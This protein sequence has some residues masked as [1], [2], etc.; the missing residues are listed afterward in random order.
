MVGALVVHTLLMLAAYRVVRKVAY[1]K[2]HSERAPR[3]GWL[4][5][6]G[7]V[8]GYV[9]ARVVF[10][11]IGATLVWSFGLW[12][13]E[14]LSLHLE[15]LGGGAVGLSVALVWAL[16]VLPD[17]WAYTPPTNTTPIGSTNTARP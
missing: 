14:L 8:V 15:F 2:G 6:L 3:L 17:K 4:G 11:F 13:M 12:G 10:A 7:W 9:V 1:D 16:K 5:P